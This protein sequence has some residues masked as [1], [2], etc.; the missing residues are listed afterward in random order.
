MKPIRN[1]ILASLALLALAGCDEEEKTDAGPIIRPVLSTVI[2]DVEAIRL[3]SYPGRAIAVQELNIAFQ[4]SGKMLARPVDVGS[5]VTAG[6]VLA[7]LD[8]APFRAQIRALEG[9]RASLI[10]TLENARVELGR[11]EKLLEKEFASQAAVDNQEAVV[12]ATAAN[13]EAV[14]GSLDSARLNLE[15]A[16]IIA[17]FEATVADTFVESFQTVTA[18]QPVMRILDTSRIKMEIAI[19]E[20]L[21]NLEPFVETIE[22]EFASLPGQKIPAEIIHVGR[23]A[24]P[25]TR[26][27][28]VT[29]RMDQPEGAPIQPGMAGKATATVRLPEDWS[30]NGI[31]V[32][33]AAV[34]SPNKA[35]PDETFV[36]VVDQQALTVSA[37]AV[38]VRSFA[39]RGLLVDGLDA[40]DRI[41][42]AGAN[43]LTEGQ[44]VRLFGEEE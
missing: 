17:P 35:K 21:I 2:G 39:E 43:S 4:V 41:V 19:P 24:S 27:Y 20:T 12:K 16:T 1:S 5:Q 15:Y 33:A 3:A 6:S 38:T 31:Q 8:P 25:S 13:L 28:P 26:T 18:R 22:V 30:Q 44:Q 42:T 7:T 23:E 40:G 34:F 32:P 14:E 11:Q 10:A 9:Q 29:I 37:R 36:W